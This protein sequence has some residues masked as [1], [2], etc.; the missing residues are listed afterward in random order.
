VP[1]CGKV[2]VGTT[3]T[4]VKEPSLEPRALDEEVEF[5]LKTAGDYLTR[6]PNRADVLS[7]FAGLRPLAA[8]KADGKKTKE[9]SRGHKIIVSLS[10]LITMT[11]GK[12]TTYRKMGED[13][14]DQAIIVAGLDERTSSTMFLP[15][16][17]HEEGTSDDDHLR[18]YGSDRS[19]IKKLIKKDPSL[20]EKLHP[21]LDFIKAEVVWAVREE[22][23]RT[24]EDVLARRVRALFLDARTSMEMAPE[25]AELLAAELNWDEQRMADEIEKYRVLAEGYILQ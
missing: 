12:W 4:L 11:G 6:V 20:G 9:I 2:V 16:H 19:H 22:M 7:V 17:G 15:I 21:K 8:P 3:D 24:I 13:A 10:S 25:V 23:A 18:F 14:I 5:I 1:W